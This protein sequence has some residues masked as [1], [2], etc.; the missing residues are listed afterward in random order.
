MRGIHRSLVNSPHKWPVARKMFP[1]DD[2]ITNIISLC[3]VTTT[4]ER[5]NIYIAL[6]PHRCALCR[7]HLSRETHRLK[8]CVAF[9]HALEIF[10]KDV[11][12]FTTG[13][14]G[15]ASRKSLEYQD[16]INPIERLHFLVRAD[17]S[18]F[19]EA[20]LIDGRAICPHPSGSL[21]RTLIKWISV[22]KG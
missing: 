19:I 18:W 12:V 7:A 6:C 21:I 13:S 15:A 3:R 17:G 11:C 14:M 20:G 4:L 10:S 9:K 5:T 2:V 8:W 16:R 1:F 22:D